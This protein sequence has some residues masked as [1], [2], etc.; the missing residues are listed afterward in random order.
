M[1]F[2]L[3]NNITQM[4]VLFIIAVAL[5]FAVNVFQKKIGK[6]S[7]PLAVIIIVVSCVIAYLIMTNN[8]NMENNTSE[9]FL[10]NPDESDS[11]IYEHFQEEQEQ[12]EPEQDVVNNQTEPIGSNETNVNEQQV[13]N[14][15]EPSVEVQ[16]SNNSNNSNT[17][18]VSDML[19]VD[20]NSLHNQVN[21]N[22]QGALEN[23]NLL[24][25]GHHI[26]VDTQGCSLRNANRGLRSEPPNPQVQVSPWLQTTICP[27][28]LRKP[29]DDL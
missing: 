26:G 1:N 17:F 13:N 15:L 21:P 25:A 18:N 7:A 20:S 12:E 2:D 6:F 23:K 19:P 5:L 29:L 11:P 14:N 3:G 9:S 28:L 8:L 27:D 22:G 4:I 10:V 24:N 16:P